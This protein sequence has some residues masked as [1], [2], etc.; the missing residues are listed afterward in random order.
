MFEI[1]LFYK[2]I[3]NKR[4]YM[5]VIL[6]YLEILLFYRLILFIFINYK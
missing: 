4:K 6:S 1:L 5:H 3:V 2:N